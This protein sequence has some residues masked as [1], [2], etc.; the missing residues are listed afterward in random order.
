MA[1]SRKL[2]ELFRALGER[3]IE[4]ASQVASQI[5][6]SRVGYALRAYQSPE[7]HDQR[8]VAARLLRVAWGIGFAT[9]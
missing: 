2:A 9:A 3:D 4:A 1:T 8:R 7:C 5:C 6:A